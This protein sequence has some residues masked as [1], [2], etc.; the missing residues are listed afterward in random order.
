M[1]ILLLLIGLGAL[2]VG[3]ALLTRAVT[4]ARARVSTTLR[5]IDEYG[6]SLGQGAPQV[7][8][9]R[10]RPG[11]LGPVADRLGRLVPAG[12]LDA[13]TLRSAGM[14]NVTPERFQGYRVILTTAVPGLLLFVT[15]AGSASLINAVLV[16]ASF[17]CCWFLPASMIRS[18]AQRRMD[19]IDRAL[20]QLVDVLTATVE[21][22]MGFAGSLRLVA[23]RFDGP[24]G[25]ELRLTLQEQSLGVSVGQSLE[26]LLERCDTPSVRAF[27]RAVGQG[28][29]LGVSVGQMLRNLAVETRKRRAQ[30]AREHMMKAPIKMLFPLVFF[31]LPALFIV[32]MYPAISSILH[33]LKTS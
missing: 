4:M 15:L 11:P 9:E 20:P 13:R 2:G 26:N 1:T 12:T 3:A 30:L 10:P 23:G 14:Y 27:V 32:L 19:E 7:L 6:I 29:E 5:N 24:L 31:M 17:A 21:A 25:R 18:R 16:I 33:A 28:E 8:V 22:G